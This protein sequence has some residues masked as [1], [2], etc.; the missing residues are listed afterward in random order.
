MH[1]QRMP[2]S[3]SCCYSPAVSGAAQELVKV[4]FEDGGEPLK[5][6]EAPVDFT[7]KSVAVGNLSEVKGCGNVP[8]AEV[9]LLRTLTDLVCEGFRQL[10][11]PEITLYR[12]SVKGP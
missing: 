2:G 8:S 10:H 3:D 7:A 12:V 9:P 11:G 1:G 6:V 5:F 4:G